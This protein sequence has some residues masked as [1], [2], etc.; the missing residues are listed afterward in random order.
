MTMR[1][2]E[3]FTAELEAQERDTKR[4]MAEIGPGD[5]PALLR[6]AGR[7]GTLRAA[8]ESDELSMDERRAAI[9]DAVGPAAILPTGP[10]RR[11]HVSQ[12]TVSTKGFTP[13][14]MRPSAPAA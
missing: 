6:F 7:K 5:A 11:A 8:W 13:L 14:R 10:D 4:R 9:K 12:R 2:Y 1:A 3:K